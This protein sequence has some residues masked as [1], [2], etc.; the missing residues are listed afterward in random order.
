[1]P[2]YQYISPALNKTMKA[3]GSFEKLDN[4]QMLG[5]RVGIRF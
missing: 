5:M 3:D 4:T 1:M 2:S